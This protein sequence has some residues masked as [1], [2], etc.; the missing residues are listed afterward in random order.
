M[1]ICKLIGTYILAGAS[2]ALGAMLLRKAVDATTNPEKRN[3]IK[4][5][6][7]KLKHKIKRD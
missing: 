1:K 4:L 6:F 3:Y 2:T 5:H 7:N